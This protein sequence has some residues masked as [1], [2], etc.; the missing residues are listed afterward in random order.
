MEE[1]INLM[2]GLYAATSPVRFETAV[3]CLSQ[4]NTEYLGLSEGL[5]LSGGAQPSSS[6]YRSIGVMCI[7]FE[8]FTLR[9]R[10]KV[11]LV[12]SN[13]V[14]IPSILMSQ[15]LILNGPKTLGYMK[16][17]FRVLLSSVLLW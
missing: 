11:T 17:L 9:L 4:V 8:I 16:C 1:P 7:L 5:S 3:S 6:I 13:M 12:V 10:S 15:N 2:S 14:H